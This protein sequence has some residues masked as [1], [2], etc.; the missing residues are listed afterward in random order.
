MSERSSDKL[1]HMANQIGKFFASQGA[2]TAP[3]AIAEHLRKFWDPRMRVG[4]L[5]HL[6]AGGAGLDPLVRD[7]IE[8]LREMMAVR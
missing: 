2:E 6:E 8:K 5:A 4:I 7:A 1:V 3:A